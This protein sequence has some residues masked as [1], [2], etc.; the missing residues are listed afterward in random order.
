M[1]EWRPAETCP[2]S[3]ISRSPHY[4]LI[5][6]GVHVGV[7]FRA[8]PNYEGDPEFMDESTEFVEGITHW[9]PLPP[10]PVSPSA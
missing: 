2:W 1:S 3:D 5:T 10:P 8:V 9:M 6:N 7:G 4:V